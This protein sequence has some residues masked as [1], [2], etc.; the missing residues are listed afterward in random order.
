M[1]CTML[2]KYWN[3]VYLNKVW[4]YSRQMDVAVASQS[5]PLQ[6]MAWDGMES[7][8]LWVGTGQQQEPRQQQ[9]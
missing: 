4:G 5:E 7:L 9:T 8:L 3:T 1:R 6:G 2:N